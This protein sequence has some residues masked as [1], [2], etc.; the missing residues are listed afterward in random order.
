MSGVPLHSIR[1]AWYQNLEKFPGKPAVVCEGVAH[2]YSECDLLSD[3]LR[4]R[5]AEQFGFGPGDK[6]AIA[7]PNRFEYFVTYWAVI[8]SGGVVVPVNTRLA[9]AETQHV[10]ARSDAE[11]ISGGPI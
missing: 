3:R 4:R 6:V 9:T 5:L 8:K 11:I 2:T 1:D 10:L 7:G